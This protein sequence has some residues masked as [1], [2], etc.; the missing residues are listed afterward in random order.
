M[1]STRSDAALTGATR[2]QQT[3]EI[4][5]VTRD[6]VITCLLAGIGAGGT[7]AGMSY[8]FNMGFQNQDVFAFSG[9]LVGAAAAVFGAAWVA[10]RATTSAKRT[11]QAIVYAVCAKLLAANRAAAAV[12]IVND[13]VNWTPEW[14][15]AIRS[16]AVDAAETRATLQQ[17]LLTAQALDFR[18]RVKITKAEQAVTFFQTFYD[19]VMGPYDDDPLDERSWSLTLLYMEDSLVEALP[20]LR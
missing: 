12:G 16:L 1:A 14:R 2:R 8:L 5:A 15:T 6:D 20:V 7:A 17:A 18:Q 4:D 10:D 11:E 9:A 13:E 19:D 3:L